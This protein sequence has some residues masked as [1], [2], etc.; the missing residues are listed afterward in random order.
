MSRKNTSFGFLS[1][2]VAYKC[3]MCSEKILCDKNV[4]SHH[5]KNKHGAT[6]KSYVSKLN[7]E[8]KLHTHT[9]HSHNQSEELSQLYNTGAK[10][11]KISEHIGNLCEFACTNC[12]YK[13]YRWQ[14]MELHKHQQKH[15]HGIQPIKHATQ[16]SL[17]KCKICADLIL[18][19]YIIIKRHLYKHNVSVAVYRNKNMQRSLHA[20]SLQT[21]FLLELKSSIKQDRKSVGEGSQIGGRW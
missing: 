3:L 17:Y 12:H 4:L 15:G 10:N 7:L 20:K 21:E 11:M 5:L 9:C 6:L 13:S 1:K 18:C 8:Y 14:L 19:D 16:L 2:I